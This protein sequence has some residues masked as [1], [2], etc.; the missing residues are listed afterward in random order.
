M[1]ID[2]HDWSPVTI[3]EVMYLP[4]FYMTVDKYNQLKNIPNGA[5]KYPAAG[6]TL[7]SVAYCNTNV[8]SHLQV[9]DFI[10]IQNF[11]EYAY[12]KI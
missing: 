8:Q 11:W 9:Q 3:L 7:S 2:L 5:K 6:R 1:R 10:R 12:Y 4:M